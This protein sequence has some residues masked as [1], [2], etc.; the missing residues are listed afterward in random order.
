MKS[1]ASVDWCDILLRYQYPDHSL[2]LSHA[3]LLFP[4]SASQIAFSYFLFFFFSLVPLLCAVIAVI[5]CPLLVLPTWFFIRH[6]QPIC[7]ARL[8]AVEKICC[9]PLR[10][11]VKPTVH[12]FYRNL[13]WGSSC[14]VAKLAQSIN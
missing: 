4:R 5:N 6:K 14:L 1:V 9:V 3:F 11:L 8:L 13:R 10:W 12:I 2:K 7:L